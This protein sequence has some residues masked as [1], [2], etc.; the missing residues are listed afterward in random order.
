MYLMY[1]SGTLRYTDALGFHA[2]SKSDGSVNFM[3]AVLL[4]VA[5]DVTTN[6][7]TH[8]LTCWCKRVSMDMHSNIVTPVMSA[9]P[10]VRDVIG[11]SC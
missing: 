10:V 3:V 1:L 11:L 8:K 4:H 5:W 2:W 9:G 7:D 6:T